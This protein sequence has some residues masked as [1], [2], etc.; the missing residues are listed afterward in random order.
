MIKM[1][2]SFDLSFAKNMSKQYLE[3]LLMDVYMEKVFLLIFDVL[4]K[5]GYASPIFKLF[6]YCL[7]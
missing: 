1:A 6:L 2:I 3:V 5:N 4:T 7:F